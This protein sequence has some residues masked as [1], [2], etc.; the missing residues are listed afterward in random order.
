MLWYERKNQ[1][2][3]ETPEIRKWSR[4]LTRGKAKS[5]I[6]RP[7]RHIFTGI[8]YRVHKNSDARFVG[9]RRPTTSAPAPRE[10]RTAHSS[11]AIRKRPTSW[12]ISDDDLTSAN[13]SRGG[14]RDLDNSFYQKGNIFFRVQCYIF[15]LFFLCF[16][17]SFLWWQHEST[18]AIPID[19]A[20]S[21]SA[22]SGATGVRTEGQTDGTARHP[23]G[24]RSYDR[25]EITRC[26]H[27]IENSVET[28]L[29]RFFSRPSYTLCFN[30]F[31]NVASTQP[32]SN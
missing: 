22:K 18:A 3:L 16:F 11:L 19:S 1:E 23:S 14:K 6:I 25:W 27:H 21:G 2:N 29:I 7:M 9:R 32:W 28:H 10:T 13:W 26:C 8:A 24:H 4:W 15:V 20:E 30:K 17:V 5:W 12:C 31:S